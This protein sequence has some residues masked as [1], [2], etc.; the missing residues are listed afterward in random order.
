MSVSA[1]TTKVSYT[2]DAST[3][4]FAVTF[5]FKGT[6]ATS[7]LTVVE[8]TIA[9]GAE[10]TKTYT[11]HFTVTGGS[12]A[13][14][15]VIAVT[16]PATTVEWHIRR[17]TT[18][19]QTSDYVT[20]DPFSADTLEGDLDRLAMAGQ[21]RDGD[22]GQAFKYPD[23]YTGGASVAMPEPVANAYLVFNAAADALTTSTTSVGQYP[24]RRRHRRTAVLQLHSGP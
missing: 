9:T 5:P 1:T 2:G 4:S 19:T 11:T 14:G 3:T 15:T 13:T 7:E 21:E 16:A 17:A 6:G 22:I 23:T 18:T 20:N 8:R 12:G 24:R 10:V